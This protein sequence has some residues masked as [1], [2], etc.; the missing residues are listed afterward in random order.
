MVFISLAMAMSK[1]QALQVSP[2]EHCA[3]Q[4]YPKALDAPAPRP[5][6]DTLTPGT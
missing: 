3:Y 5:S 1:E 4:E 2:R 6:E